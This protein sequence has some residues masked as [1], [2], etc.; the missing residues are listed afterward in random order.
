M[1]SLFVKVRSTL[2]IVQDLDFG[3]GQSVFTKDGMASLEEGK[4][5]HLLLTLGANVAET[6]KRG[7]CVYFRVGG[8]GCPFIYLLLLFS[9]R[10]SGNGGWR[11]GGIANG[12][13]EGPISP[14][15]WHHNHSG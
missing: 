8:M 5:T 4:L 13:G 10:R 14:P 6:R 3:S 12:V 11:N 1:T 9:R 7:E 2:R 15:F